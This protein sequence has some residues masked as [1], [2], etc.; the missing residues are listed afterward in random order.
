MKPKHLDVMF[1]QETHSDISNQTDWNR[2]CMGMVF[3]DHSSSTSAGV[4]ILFSETFSPDSERVK[5]VVQGR[6]S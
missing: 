2:E 5:S 4:R 1:L 6:L 3:L